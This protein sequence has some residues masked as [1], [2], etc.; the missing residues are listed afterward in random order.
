M[1]LVTKQEVGKTQ[2]RAEE[3]GSPS[4]LFRGCYCESDLGRLHPICTLGLNSFLDMMDSV[5]MALYST[6]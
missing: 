6:S 5:L 3:R 4:Q 2:G 1:E